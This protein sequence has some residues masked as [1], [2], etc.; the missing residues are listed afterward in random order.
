MVG[1]LQY[2]QENIVWCTCTIYFDSIMSD[3]NGLV[4]VE[5]LN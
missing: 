4:S 5:A 1:D 3:D 2:A